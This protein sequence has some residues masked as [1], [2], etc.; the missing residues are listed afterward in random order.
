MAGWQRGQVGKDQPPCAPSASLETES[1]QPPP[2]ARPPAAA[3]GQELGSEPSFPRPHP[4]GTPPPSCWAEESLPDLG[5][6]PG[7]LQLDRRQAAQG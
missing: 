3:P 4:M 7:E 6:S 2:P 5:G 1:S